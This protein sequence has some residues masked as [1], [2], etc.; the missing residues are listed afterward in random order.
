MHLS[1]TCHVGIGYL[2][3][4]YPVTGKSGTLPLLISLDI[5]GHKATYL[6][7][8]RGREKPRARPTHCHSVRNSDVLAFGRT[9]QLH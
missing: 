7:E 8:L 3:L 5:D 4:C 9:P 1:F 2:L 6:H